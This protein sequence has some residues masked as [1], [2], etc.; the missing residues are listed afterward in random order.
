MRVDRDAL[1]LAAPE[2]RRYLPLFPLSLFQLRS[3]A[4]GQGAYFLQR[5]S[6]QT[7]GTPWRLTRASYVAYEGEQHGFRKAE[8]ITHSID[9]ELAFY[10]RIL[11][12][13][14]AGDVPDVHLENLAS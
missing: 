6:W 2:G 13:T 9:T 10:A 5:C 11:G 4:G 1:L 14:P 7:E 8:T 12:F 3:G